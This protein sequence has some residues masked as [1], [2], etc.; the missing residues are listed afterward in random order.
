MSTIIQQGR[1]TSGGGVTTLVV[2]SDVDW[3]KVIN[4]TVINAATATYGAEF[5]W[6]RGMAVNDGT[7]NAF[8]GAGTGMVMSTAAAGGV[9]GFTLVD[10]STNPLTAQVVTT[11]ATDVVAPVVD[12]GDTT[13]LADGS[14]VRLYTM[15]GQ[16]S[17][18]GYDFEVDTIVNNVSFTISYAMAN[19][20]C[21]AAGAGSYRIVKWDPIFY[22]RWRFIANITQA[23]SAV[24][25][26]TVS[27]GYTVGQ[28]IRFKIPAVF[29]MVELNGLQGSITAVTAGTFTVDI[30]TT[31]F[32]AF[33]FA[34]PADVPFSPAI[35]SPLGEDVSVARNA[36]V[37]E[38]LDATDNIAYIGM[39]LGAGNTSPSGNVNDVIY[40]TAGKSFKVTNQ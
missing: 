13:G 15:V 9:D 38:L 34:L 35:V 18:A 36:S 32:T 4:Y 37:D 1:F 22:P 29:D 5:Y 6:Q 27:H 20:P 30:D 3:V 14:I 21:A 19:A 33:A 23:A 40:W 24:I 8:D 39:D 31:A 2:R 10:T 25:T 28:I 17:L 7:I 12:T 16:E 26:T 11:A